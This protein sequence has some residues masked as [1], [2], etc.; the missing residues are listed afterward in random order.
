MVLR[1]VVTKVDELDVLKL[2][3][4]DVLILDELDELI[5]DELDELTSR[6]QLRL[7]PGVIFTECL[8]WTLFFGP[9]DLTFSHVT[10]K[11]GTLDVFICL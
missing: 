9:D 10:F 7:G 5:L 4:L 11:S 3:E 1:G 2:D 8:F 6:L